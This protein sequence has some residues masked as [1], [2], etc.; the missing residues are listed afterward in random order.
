[1]QPFRDQVFIATKF[2]FEIEAGKVVGV[3]SRSKY[4]KRSAE[5]SL[6]RLRTDCLD[7]FYQH[8]ID[9]DA[10]IENVAGAVQ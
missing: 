10:P 6:R 5:G 1:M 2:G 7:L 9:H 4:L 8:R 3:N